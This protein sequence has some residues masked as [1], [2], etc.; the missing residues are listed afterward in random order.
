M[1]TKLIAAEEAR[2]MREQSIV[3]F[4]DKGMVKFIKHLNK[5][6]EE[7][8]AKGMWGFSLLVEY[9][10]DVEPD[11]V[12][13]ELSSVQIKELIKHLENN[14]YRAWIYNGCFNVRWDELKEEPEQIHTEV[15]VIKPWYKFW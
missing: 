1:M 2:N 13:S 8:T 14:G 4:N 15:P 3:D 11:K 12:F 6:I 10:Y 9:C 7:E 5:K